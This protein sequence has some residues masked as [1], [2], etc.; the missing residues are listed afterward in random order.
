MIDSFFNS[1]HCLSGAHCRTCRR[2]RHWRKSMMEFFSDIDKVDFECK[3]GG[4]PPTHKVRK[5]RIIPNRLERMKVAELAEEMKG[6]ELDDEANEILTTYITDHPRHHDEC[7]DRMRIWIAEKED[8]KQQGLPPKLILTHDGVDYEIPEKF[9][10]A[11]SHDLADAMRKLPLDKWG[12]SLLRRHVKAEWKG[13][14]PSCQE[15]SHINMM[16]LWLTI[17]SPS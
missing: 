9:Q 4:R 5:Y 7:A 15:S 10:Y 14:C 2:D 13:P 17:N 12:K 16:R 6:Y 11:G 1:V 3:W 8:L